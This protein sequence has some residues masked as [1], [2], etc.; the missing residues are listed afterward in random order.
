M[1]L[2]LKEVDIGDKTIGRRI[3][4]SHGIGDGIT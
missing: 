2:P 1:Y 3:R 4:N